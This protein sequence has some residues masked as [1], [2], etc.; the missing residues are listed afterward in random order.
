MPTPKI[1]SHNENYPHFITFTI[2]EWIDVFTKPEYFAVLLDSLR[3][4]QKSLGL[5]IYGYVFMTNHMHLLCQ[6]RDG[7][8]LSKIVQSYKRFTTEKIKQLVI[9]DSREYI[10]DLMFTERIPSVSAETTGNQ[11]QKFQLWQDY[12]YPEVIASEKFFSEK[13]NY[14]HNNPVKK[15]YV[16]KPEDWLYFSAGF[17]LTGKVGPLKIDNIEN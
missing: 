12:N 11:Q 13:L 8:Q 3:Y 7:Y 5:K 15:E 16:A 2:V 9:K 14:I 6:A 4:C 10:A 17:Y 1:H